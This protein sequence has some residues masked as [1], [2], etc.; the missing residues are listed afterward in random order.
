MAHLS[1]YFHNLPFCARLVH[2]NAGAACFR[3]EDYA[4]AAEHFQRGSDEGDANS[5][6]RL[7]MLYYTGS[8]VERDPAKAAALWHLAAD[9]GNAIAECNLGA[10]YQNGD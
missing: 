9:Q 6:L 1:A 2:Y 3:R 8:G 7:G 5:Q 10:A 4:A